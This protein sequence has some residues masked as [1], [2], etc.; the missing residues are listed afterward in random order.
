MVHGYGNDI[1]WTFQATPIFLAQNGFASFALDLQGHGLSQGL[2]A[3]VPNVDLLVDDCIS[4]FNCVLTQDPTL[5]NLPRFLYDL[6]NPLRPPL[7]VESSVWSMAMAMT[8][9]GLFK[10]PQ[11]SLP[12]TGLPPL[13]LIYRAMA[14]PKASRPMSPMLTFLLMTASRS[15]TVY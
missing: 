6:G 7:R 1:S 15:S 3:Y 8:L 14:S 5:Q 2:K 4:F 11:S 9:A 10:P 12:K 13:P